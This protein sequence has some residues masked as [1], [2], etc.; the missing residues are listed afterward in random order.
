MNEANRAV[1]EAARDVAVESRLKLRCALETM[2]S[3]VPL[4]L[5]HVSPHFRKGNL[6][7]FD[8]LSCFS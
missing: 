1:R 4:T 7:C 8:L 3:W 5:C 6:T 2:N